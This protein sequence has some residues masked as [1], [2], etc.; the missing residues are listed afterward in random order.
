MHEV[1]VHRQERRL[2]Q[3]QDRDVHA[4]AALRRQRLGHARHQSLWKDGEPLFYDE[5]GYA[6][7]VRHRALVHRRPAQA[8]PVAAGVHQPDGELLPPAG[9]GLR[10]A[11][12]PGL[13]GRQPLGLRSASRSPARTR[14]PSASS[15]ACPTRRR[16]PYLAFSAHAD[17]RP[18]RHQEQDRAAGAG[19]QGPL[20]AAAG[21]ARRRSRRC[22]ARSTR[23]STRLEADHEFLH[24]GRR[25][26][27]RPDRD[28]DRLQARPTRSTRSGCARTRTS[29]SCTTTSDRP[30]R[31]HPLAAPGAARSS[32]RG[33]PD[34]SWVSGVRASCPWWTRRERLGWVRATTARRSSPARPPRCRRRAPAPSSP[35][36]SRLAPRTGRSLFSRTTRLIQAGPRSRRSGARRRAS[37][38]RWSTG[39]PRR[40]RPSRTPTAHGA[41]SRVRIGSRSN[42]A[43]AGTRLPW[44]STENTTT[45]TTMP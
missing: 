26:H 17:G 20:R 19:R 3:R 22:P 4:E 6:R 18:R 8:R 45:T 40:G 33:R 39:A 29:S 11:G 36:R 23:C 14:R 37:R 28:L 41:R 24:R 25:L 30:A 44:T 35:A 12:Q 13:L 10:G 31:G 21:G 32:D 38:R 27:R 5:T 15:S 43:T 16:N 34:R 7:P 2:A 9:A 1:Q 42:P